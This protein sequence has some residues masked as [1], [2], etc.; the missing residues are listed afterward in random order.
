MIII[1]AIVII[2][3]MLE[4]FSI[5]RLCTRLI[6]VIKSCICIMK[7]ENLHDR[8]KGIYILLWRN[9]LPQNY[10][11]QNFKSGDIRISCHRG[12]C[13]IGDRSMWCGVGPAPTQK[14]QWGAR[15]STR[16]PR[17]WIGNQA[18]IVPRQL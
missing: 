16:Y 6:F 12:T 13:N 17:P 7:K 11:V 14:G 5:N 1:V 10:Q 2:I 8:N 9:K 15:S 3:L 4:I 18:V